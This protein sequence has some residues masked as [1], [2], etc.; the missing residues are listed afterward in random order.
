V[1]RALLDA[2]HEGWIVVESDQS[3]HPAASALLAGYLVQRELRPL[4]DEKEA[5]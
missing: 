5:A 3:P 1:T 2:G 4:I